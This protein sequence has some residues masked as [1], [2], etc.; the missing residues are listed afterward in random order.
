M[1]IDSPVA[2]DL[3]DDP[4]QAAVPTRLSAGV[5]P[6]LLRGIS[7]LLFSAATLLT[8]VGVAA[9]VV[10]GANLAL[11]LLVGY[12]AFAATIAM[13]RSAAPAVGPRGTIDLIAAAPLAAEPQTT[14]AAWKLVSTFTVADASRLL[15][16]VEPGAAATQE[17]IAWGRALLDAIKAGDLAI[18][19]KA[20][21]APGAADR[22]RESP[23][24]MTEVTREALAGWADQKGSVPDFLRP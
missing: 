23:H 18:A 3:I 7:P 22:E 8:G 1:S 19:S 24:Y 12:S 13:L 20:S 21:T 2:D 11:T 14:T 16:H 5:S 10:T 15:S 9:A 17:S 4:Q 6:G